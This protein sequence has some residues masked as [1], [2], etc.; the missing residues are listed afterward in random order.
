V[1]RKDKGSHYVDFSAALEKGGTNIIWHRFEK[2]NLWGGGERLVIQRKSQSLKRS[3][4]PKEAR[5]CV[6]VEMGFYRTFKRKLRRILT[7]HWKKGRGC[8]GNR[9]KKR[10][11][12]EAHR[13]VNAGS[14]ERPTCGSAGGGNERGL[15]TC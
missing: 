3:H 12:Q 1:K 4:L 2:K 7:L 10:S 5:K 9:V 15:S 13:L 8:L 14:Q 11:G 6:K